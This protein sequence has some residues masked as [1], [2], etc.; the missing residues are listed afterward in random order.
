MTEKEEI[1]I[2]QIFET[3]VESKNELNALKASE[4]RVRLDSKIKQCT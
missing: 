2:E 1:T 4:T 3:I